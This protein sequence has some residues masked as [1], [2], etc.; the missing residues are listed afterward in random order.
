MAFSL[1]P[2]TAHQLSPAQHER[3]E[4]MTDAEI[5]AAALGDADSPPSPRMSLASSGALGSCGR[6]GSI[7]A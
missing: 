1:D 3:L 7:P 4:R 2:E 5:T 6:P